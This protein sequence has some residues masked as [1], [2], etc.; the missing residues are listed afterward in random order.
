MI[1][2]DSSREYCAAGDIRSPVWLHGV[3]S[4]QSLMAWKLP[5]VGDGASHADGVRF[6]EEP[7]DRWYAGTF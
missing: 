3:S 5:Y 7:F 1:R 6:R 2:W 4:F